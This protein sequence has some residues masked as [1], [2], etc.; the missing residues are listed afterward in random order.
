MDVTEQ[1]PIEAQEPREIHDR[2][3]DE[4]RENTVG[5]DDSDILTFEGE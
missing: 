3:L 2:E 5:P 4:W 1:G